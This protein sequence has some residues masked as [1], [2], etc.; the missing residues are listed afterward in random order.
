[1]KRANKCPK[2]QQMIRFP[3]L[4]NWRKF[5]DSKLKVNLA[6]YNKENVDGNKDKENNKS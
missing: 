2:C 4:V 6:K 5:M 3:E 1:M